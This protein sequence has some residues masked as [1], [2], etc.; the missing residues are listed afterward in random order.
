L[1]EPDV[2]VYL[3]RLTRSVGRNAH[4]PIAC[5]PIGVQKD[6][7]VVACTSNVEAVRRGVQIDGR[8]I[9]AKVDALAI[10]RRARRRPERR[11]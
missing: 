7:V 5:E 1:T 3:Q 9:G 6:M 2:A 10:G 4:I 8:A 11:L